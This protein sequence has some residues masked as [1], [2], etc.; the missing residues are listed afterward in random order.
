M[1][2]TKNFVMLNYPKT[3]STF[4]RSVIKAIFE[5]REQK[6]SPFI[7]QVRRLFN[8]W[9]Y[10]ELL[11]PSTWLKGADVPHQSQHGGYIHIPKSH[12][13]KHIFSVIR[14]PL[15]RFAS[16]YEFKFW[17]QKPFLSQDFLSSKYPGFP[18][19]SIE[20]FYEY[21]IDTML[22]GRLSKPDDSLNLGPQTVQFIQM[23]F[24]DPYRILD[25]MSEKYLES[26]EYLKDIAPVTFLKQ[27]NLRTELYDLLLKQHNF[28]P[29][30]LE[31]I[32]TAPSQNVTK[33]F[34]RVEDIA[35]PSEIKT[36]I[37]YRERFLFKILK[38]IGIDYSI[39][40]SN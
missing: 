20:Q 26:D 33:A 15:V 24:K 23:F 4:S 28:N 17:E 3:G 16:L 6:R 39:H 9:D 25:N 2:I 7:K 40:N 37:L 10:Y 1:I 13:N 35:I 30:E 22:Y 14:N 36:K 31:I 5:Q 38:N 34:S 18:N 12:R 11:V 21:H 29:A 19:L 32:F 27:E 8:I